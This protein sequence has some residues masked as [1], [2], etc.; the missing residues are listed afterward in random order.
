MM[1][2]LLLIQRIVTF[3]DLLK[4]ASPVSARS[5]FNRSEGQEKRLAAGKI[6][7]YKQVFCVQG[8]KS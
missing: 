5:F 3:R 4:K 1:V 7:V 2:A 6:P 8:V